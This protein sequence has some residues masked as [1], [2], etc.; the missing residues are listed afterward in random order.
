LADEVCIAA[1]SDKIG[2]AVPSRDN[3]NMQ[4][5]RQPRPGAPAEVHT[6]IETVRLYRKCKRLLS[7][8]CQLCHFKKLFVAG[9]VEIG[10]MTVWRYKKVPIIVRKSVEHRDAVFCPPQDKIAAVILRGPDVSA[11]ET[12]VLV[13]KTLYIADSPRRPEILSF[14]HFNNPTIY[15]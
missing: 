4:M 8:P 15:R 9:L 7:I 13:G 1:G 5:V 2:V 10:D 11:N 12:F 6:Y 3:V 14:R